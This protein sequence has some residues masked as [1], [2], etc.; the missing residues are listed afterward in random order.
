MK[1]GEVE[2]ARARREEPRGE[3]K[4]RERQKQEKPPDTSND[5]ESDTRIM[6]EKAG[7]ERYVTFDCTI[8]RIQTQFCEGGPA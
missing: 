7:L 8:V 2:R 6:R 5:G 1:P 4:R 3:W